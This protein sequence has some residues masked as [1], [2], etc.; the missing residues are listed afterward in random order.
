MEAFGC[1]GV[2]WSSVLWE[3][4]ESSIVDVI[5]ETETEQRASVTIRARR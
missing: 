1:R 5:I 2:F 4:K 3:G